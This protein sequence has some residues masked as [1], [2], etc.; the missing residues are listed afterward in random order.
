MRREMNKISWSPSTSLTCIDYKIKPSKL[1]SIWKLSKLT[2]KFVRQLDQFSLKKPLRCWRKSIVIWD[3]MLLTSSTLTLK[4]AI[5]TLWDSLSPL[6]DSL[7][8]WPVS[9][10]IL[11]S[12]KA[13]S[14]RSVGW[15]EHQTSI[16]RSKIWSSWRIRNSSIMR[17]GN[18]SKLREKKNKSSKPRSN[19]H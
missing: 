5:G 8:L 13:M 9:M 3:K 19:H 2:S 14:K 10:L 7:K 12:A 4:L 18:V 17:I 15:W 1:T 16:S 6:L 11:R